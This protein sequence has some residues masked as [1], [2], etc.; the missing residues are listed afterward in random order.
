MI[1]ERVEKDGIVDAIYE[2]SNIVASSYDKIKKNLNITFVYGGNYTYQGVPETDY[3]RFE[4]SDSQGKVLGSHIKKYP[5]LK[6][7]NVDVNVIFNKV[8]DVKLKEASVGVVRLT[9][10]INELTKTLN[11]ELIPVKNRLS[12]FDD[13][14]N[15][16]NKIIKQY[17]I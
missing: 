11:D 10:L 13:G 17:K 4:T 2:S 7:E 6:H 1:L 3:M 8:S 5:A 12:V 9:Y 14:L 16:V 15:E